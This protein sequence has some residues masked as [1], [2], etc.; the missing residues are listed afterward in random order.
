MTYKKS[1][2]GMALFEELKCG[3]DIDRIAH[4][5]FIQRADHVAELEPG[6]DDAMMTIIAM[7]EG[8]AFHLSEKELRKLAAELLEP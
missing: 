8:P 5:A 3:F 2:F 6:L 4:W 7:G 1:D